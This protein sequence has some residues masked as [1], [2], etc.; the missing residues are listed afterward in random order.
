MY[1]DPQKIL[2]VSLWV[3]ILSVKG[4]VVSDSKN[5]GSLIC[6]IVSQV[7]FSGSVVI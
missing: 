6:R 7:A 5:P 1:T 3:K 2:T 4:V